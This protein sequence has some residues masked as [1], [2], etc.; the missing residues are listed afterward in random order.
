L[1]DIPATLERLAVFAGRWPADPH[2]R[3]RLPRL[4]QLLGKRQVPSERHGHMHLVSLIK[5]FRPTTDHRKG[6][7]RGGAC[8]SRKYTKKANKRLHA[9]GSFVAEA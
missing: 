9:I 8:A 3:N 7:I 6:I 1:P 5:Q 4:S 2:G